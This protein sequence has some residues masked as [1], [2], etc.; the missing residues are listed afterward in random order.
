MP[1]R[2]NLFTLAR[3]GLNGC[4]MSDIEMLERP[5]V[6]KAVQKA[7]DLFHRAKK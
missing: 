3:T 4:W 6:S 2:V 5:D 1:V 7:N